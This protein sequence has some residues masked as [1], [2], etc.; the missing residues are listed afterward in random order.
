MH[1]G[2]TAFILALC[3]ALTASS[4]G[5]EPGQPKKNS[6]RVVYNFAGTGSGAS[7]FAGLTQDAEGNFYGTT[8]QG[9]GVNGAGTVF[10]LTPDETESV[11]YSFTDGSDGGIPYGGVVR[12]QEGNL[13]G[14]TSS[15]GQ[16]QCNCGVVYKIDTAG[17]ESVLHTFVGGADGATPYGSLVMDADGNLYGTTFD[18]GGT[19][20]CGTV[21]K[22]APNGKETVLHAF[23]GG[24]DGAN[25]YSSLIMD[26]R[27]DLTGATYQ[28]GGAA[29]NCGTVFTLRGHKESV[30]YVFTG[31]SDGAY[32]QTS[33][34]QDKQ[35]NLYGT[36][37]FGGAFS[38]GT[39]F[40]LAPDNSETVLHPFSGGADG[41]SPY[42]GLVADRDGNLYGT[43]QEGGVSDA[44]TVFKVAPDGSAESVLYAFTGGVDGDQP[45]AGLFLGAKSELY[46]TASAGGTNGFGTVFKVKD[47]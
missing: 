35:G 13:Y 20:N 37:K 31:G 41:A 19:C 39:V 22:L 3:V 34:I 27:G 7:P 26:K 25:P 14:T 5:A 28:G 45:V 43:T 10:K 15:G 16:P 38:G 46:G 12:D 9:G 47:R 36:T 2:S 17:H 24:A 23:E 40:K 44:G 32:P 1:R 21:F 29:C 42:A 30:L 8:I 11:L 33:L 6:F 4:A 18:G